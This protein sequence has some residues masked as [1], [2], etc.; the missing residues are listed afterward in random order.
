MKAREEKR[1]QAFQKYNERNKELTSGPSYSSSLP[2]EIIDQ[3][4]AKGETLLEK[5]KRQLADAKRKILDA[6]AGRVKRSYD[7][8]TGNAPKLYDSQEYSGDFDWRAAGCLDENC[9]RFKVNKIQKVDKEE[10]DQNKVKGG[11]YAWKIKG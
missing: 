7:R 8:I 3:N 4:K 9:D 6:T 2:Q 5:G 1:W 11:N 10:R